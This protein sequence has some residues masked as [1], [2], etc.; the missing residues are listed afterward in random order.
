MSA[1]L[2]FPDPQAAADLL[3][4]ASRA[5]RLGDGTV[6]LRADGG[7][8]VTTAA[9]LAPRGLLD[10][11][12]TVLGLRVSAIDP[13]LECDLVVE[14]AALLPAPDD[15]QAVVLPDTATSPAWAGISPPRG[16]WE[17]KDAIDAAVLASRAQYGVAAVADALPENAGEDVV[18]VVR[19][20]VWGQPDEALGGLPL[21][22]AFAAFALGFIAGGE[23]AVVRTS[24]S[25]T[26]VTLA[27]GHVLV[28]GP[29][30][31]GLTPV[32]STGA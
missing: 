13:E 5:V 7:V 22:T 8:L 17:Q 11:T 1:R 9:P 14:A 4:F 21:G 10:A 30:R 27:R 2:M 25:W 12:P 23:E 3:T 6:R 19:G 29:V 24:G 16:G 18:R 20:Q 32:R 28:R 31:S 26:R 15:A